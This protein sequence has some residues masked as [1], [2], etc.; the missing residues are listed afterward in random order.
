[1][2]L[3]VYRSMGNYRP[4]DLKTHR[5][6][7]I[8]LLSSY[9]HV[10]TTPVD[11]PGHAGLGRLRVYRNRLV[12]QRGQGGAGSGRRCVLGRDLPGRRWV[13]AFGSIRLATVKKEGLAA[14]TIAS[15]AFAIA[16]QLV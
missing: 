4:I 2:G 3:S 5:P 15:R 12:G 13:V 6:K 8:V 14:T 16:G 7:I 11:R 1:M 9:D 10:H